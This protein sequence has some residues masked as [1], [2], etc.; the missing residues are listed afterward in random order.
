MSNE[1]E[2]VV[3][4]KDNS[5]AAMASAA[6]GQKKVADAALE[7]RKASL[8]AA[9]AD[10]QLKKAQ[11]DVASVAEKVKTGELE[12]AAAMEKSSEASR[13]LERASIKVEEAHRKVATSSHELAKAQGEVEASFRRAGNEAEK[14]GGLFSG[15][16]SKIGS[17]NPFKNFGKDAAS[18]GQDAGSSLAKG[19]ES[20]AESGFAGISE[21]LMPV[22]VGAALAAAPIAGAAIGAALV[23]GI[24]AGLAGLGMVFALKGKDITASLEKSAKAAKDPMMKSFL[25]IGAG[26]SKALTDISKPFR[27][28]WKTLESVMKGVGHTFLGPLKDAFKQMA[29]AIGSF[30]TD[31]GTAF[32]TLAPAIK[33]LSTAFTALLGNLGPRLSGVF[34]QIADALIQM[35]NIIAKNPRPFAS[36]ILGAMELI[37]ITIKIISA[38]SA[39]WVAFEHGLY[40]LNNFSKSLGSAFMSGV[41]A[42]GDFFSRVGS[43]AQK[44]FGFLEHLRGIL[45]SVVAFFAHPLTLGLKV[46][47]MASGPM[48]KVMSLAMG[49]AGKAFR[50]V[51]SVLDKA[52]SVIGSVASHAF[53]FARGR[54]QAALTA[55]NRAG[56]VINSVIHMAVSFA[57]ARYQ[58]A[59]TA[60]NRAGGVISSVVGMARRFASG[61]YQAALT[62]LNN[63]WAAFNSAM[64]LGRQ[65]ASKVFSATFNVLKNINP[66]AHGGVVGGQAFASGGLSGGL[67][68]VKGY[69]SGGALAMV[70]E[71]GPELV[72]LPYGST[73]YS[74]PDTQSMIATSGSSNA[75]LAAAGSSPSS[76]NPS[77][78]RRS[79]TSG[80]VRHDYMPADTSSATDS[81]SGSGGSS[82]AAQDVN[83]KIQLEWI[84]HNAGD[85]FF[86]WLRKNIRVKAGSGSNSVQVALGP[87]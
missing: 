56:G 54:Y 26:A 63:V 25:E 21:I 24:G 12:G 87:G 22:L 58:A 62:A 50:A 23:L 77:S 65:W 41:H 86:K 46:L 32:E 60:I 17:I 8:A 80:G 73:V 13:N 76:R 75:H 83:V 66:F 85:E 36:I 51:L 7:H 2:I 47:D 11:A 6:A 74:H 5:S 49:F 84:G 18:A 44:A 1:V 38:L 78:G 33:P 3:T 55:V 37:T 72:R 81:G 43:G 28:T 4:G 52:G 82:A 31:L 19:T 64:N 40:V 79:W 9:D 69:A 30:I 16:F 67:G 42:V 20:A 29:P 35:S 70:G 14:T 45:V 27:E 61:R 39:T 15:L 10:N 34:Q 48:R 71:A 57:R 68:S 59:L 53:S